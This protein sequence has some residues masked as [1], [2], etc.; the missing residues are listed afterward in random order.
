MRERAGRFGITEQQE[1]IRGHTDYTPSAFAFDILVSAARKPKD[2]Y[3]IRK[4]LGNVYG[5]FVGHNYIDCVLVLDVPETNL[6]EFGDE[7]GIRVE[8]KNEW[9][10][11]VVPTSG[12]KNNVVEMVRRAE[13]YIN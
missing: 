7:F 12:E 2:V 13:T 3:N 6:V 1:V 4:N 8:I 5:D 11:A 10:R 9:I